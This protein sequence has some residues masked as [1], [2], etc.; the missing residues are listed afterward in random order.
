MKKRTLEELKGIAVAVTEEELIQEVGDAIA[1]H[2]EQLVNGHW[3][4]D[5]GH[6]VKLNVHT[7]KLIESLILLGLYREYQ[8]SY[9]KFFDE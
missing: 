8:K 5:H 1:N 2:L 6:D 3:R 4:D 9:E 7:Q